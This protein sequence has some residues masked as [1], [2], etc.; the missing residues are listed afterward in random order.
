MT[1]L[2]A[3]LFIVP[4]V[5]LALVYFARG[6]ALAPSWPRSAIKTGSVAALVP[7]GLLLG[8]PPAVV[9]GLAL[10]AM[11]DFFLS[12]PSDRAFLAGMG[13]FAA[14][15][16]AYVAAFWTLGAGGGAPVLA[17][18]LFGLLSLSTEVWLAPRTGALR[19][20][21]RGYVV[22]ITLMGIAAFALPAGYGIA[23]LGAILF[24]LSDLILALELF[25][26]PD[27]SPVR[28]V[29]QR[30]LWLLYWSGQ[31]L[32]LAGLLPEVPL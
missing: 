21:V 9:L 1:A 18:I 20:P 15:H 7:V 23:R 8:A 11:G 12:R 16:L 13:A 24:V 28:P 14:G 19:W 3:S 25:V 30:L 26:L 22:V 32:I 6:A 5:G 17:A 10:G 4:A 29:L 2:L 31:A 27:G